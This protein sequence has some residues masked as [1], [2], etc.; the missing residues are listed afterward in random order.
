LRLLHKA[1]NFKHYSKI[2]RVIRSSLELG[3]SRVASVVDLELPVQ[4][5]MT[6]LPMFRTKGI[7]A[8]S[9]MIAKGAKLPEV[10]LRVSGN[11]HEAAGACAV[12]KVLSTTELPGN[13]VIFGVP[14]KRSSVVLR[15]AL[16]SG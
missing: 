10:K 4:W 6:T 16:Q 5:A 1:P 13:A 2:W 7:R 14:G 11:A 12:P 8:F 9:K 3:S 15:S